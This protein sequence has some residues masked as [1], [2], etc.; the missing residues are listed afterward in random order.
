MEIPERTI[1]GHEPVTEPVLETSLSLGVASTRDFIM[2]QKE[3]TAYKR[4]LRARE[5]R[6]IPIGFQIP[7]PRRWKRVEA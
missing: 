7:E 2:N 3:Q 6:R 5:A 1:P 4:E